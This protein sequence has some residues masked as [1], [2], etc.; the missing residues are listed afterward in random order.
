MR[1]V[2]NPAAKECQPRHHFEHSYEMVEN[3]QPSTVTLLTFVAV[4]WAPSRGEHSHKPRRRKSR[5]P[6]ELVWNGTTPRRNT[7]LPRKLTHGVPDSRR[8]PTVVRLSTAVVAGREA[9][10]GVGSESRSCGQERCRSSINAQSRRRPRV[11]G[12]MISNVTEQLYKLI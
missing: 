5:C 7:T 1:R 3:R 12:M 6:P 2:P 11:S 10:L 8:G 4:S 9:R